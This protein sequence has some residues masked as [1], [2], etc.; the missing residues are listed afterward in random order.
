MMA[1][2]NPIPFRI[3]FRFADWAIHLHNKRCLVT[4]KIRDEPRDDLLTSKVDP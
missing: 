1:R 3:V 2:K 4:V